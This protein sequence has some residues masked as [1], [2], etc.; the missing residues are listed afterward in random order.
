MNQSIIV[1]VT[2]VKE[3]IEYL[4]PFNVDILMAEDMTESLIR[5]EGWERFNPHTTLL[6]FPG[7][8]ADILR[9][10]LPEDWL[11]HWQW[12]TCHAKR[13]WI[14][15]QP[16]TVAAGRIF[17][18]QMVLGLSDV[19]LIDDV[20][21]SGLTSKRVL[22][23]NKPWLPGSRWHTVAWVAQKAHNVRGFT[24]YYAPIEVG[25]T[26]TKV[27]INSLST[28]LRNSEIAKSYAKRNFGYKAQDFLSILKKIR[29]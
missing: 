9:S 3:K 16:P 13:S 15:G 17:R 4:R 8:G 5:W 21:S 22:R 1:D 6:V 19:I 11:N 28:L 25:D 27:P 2:S 24:S 20:I 7:N 26:K 10:Y 12:T 29:L 14:P 23:A 18:E